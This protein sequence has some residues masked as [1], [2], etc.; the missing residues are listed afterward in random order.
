MSN[1]LS[2]LLG[3]RVVQKDISQDAACE[4]TRS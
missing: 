2:E 4:P 3:D 1:L